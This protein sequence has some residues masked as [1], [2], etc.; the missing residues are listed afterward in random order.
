[1]VI[2][3]IV[4]RAKGTLRG[5]Y[6]RK[7]FTAARI[8]DSVCGLCCVA[9]RVAARS[10]DGARDCLLEEATGGRPWPAGAA[11]GPSTAGNTELQWRDGARDAAHRV[12]ASFGGIEPSR[13]GNFVH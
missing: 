2:W 5:V 9:T 3:R 8:A 7:A 12:V 11:D 6:R 10:G 1:M 4:S 13:R